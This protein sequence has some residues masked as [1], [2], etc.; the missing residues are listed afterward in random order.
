MAVEVLALLVETVVET[1][2]REAAVD[3]EMAAAQEMKVAILPQKV[4]M[5]ALVLVLET[6]AVEV[7]GVLI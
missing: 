7:E 5:V 2:G 4:T 6:M 3:L 1:V